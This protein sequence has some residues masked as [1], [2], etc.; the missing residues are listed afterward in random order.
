MRRNSLEWIVLATSLA[1][2]TIL[3]GYLLVSALT[4]TSDGARLR[5]VAAEGAPAADGV[6]WQVPVTLANEGDEAAVAVVVE[7]SAI[8]AGSEEVVELTVD[9]MPQGGS[10]VALVVLF[11][12]PPDGPV[13][14]RV[15][16]YERP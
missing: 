12:G 13:S 2:L 6:A 9:L 8:V 3:V 7:A 1:A 4:G 14:V 5:A 16:G 11:S 10:R 15:V